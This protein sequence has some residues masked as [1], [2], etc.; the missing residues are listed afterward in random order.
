MATRKEVAEQAGVSEATVSRVLNGVGPIKESTRQRVLEAAKRLNYQLNAVAASFARGRSGNIG[1]VLPH[2][3]KVR[4]FS[5]YYFSEMLNGIGE[6]VRAS[7]LGLL[8]LYRDP[9]APFDYASLF[10]TQRVDGCL[11]LGTS[12]LPQERD[13]IGRLAELDVPFCVVDQRFED[14][15]FPSVCA[16]HVDG[17][18][19]AA[20]HLLEQGHRRIGFLNG[21][22]H[23]S[24]SADRAEGFRRALAEAGI[25]PDEAPLYEGNYSRK[26]G[27]EAAP[28]VHRDLGSLDAV[29]CA[30][31]RMAIGLA[32]GLKEKGCRLPRD[33]A[34]VGCDD[35]DAAALFDPALTTVRVPF[36]EMGLLAAERLLLRLNGTEEDA[37]TQREPVMLPTR[38][39]VRKSSL[40]GEEQLA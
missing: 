10:R 32:Q 26:S 34:I 9:G 23:Y 21:S 22:P 28:L 6:A 17:T 27:Y 40:S 20:R 13:D 38:L 1:V 18:L 37:R 31:D 25:P 11:L 30:N 5:T 16:D 8:L 14:A 2:V 39:I 29:L 15:R 4:L 19:Q 12:S 36:Y 33:L 7:G 35:S 24:N 3:P